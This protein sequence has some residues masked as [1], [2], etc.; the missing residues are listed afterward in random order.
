MGFCLAMSSYNMT[1]DVARET[2]TQNADT[3]QVERS[4]STY[5]RTVP[6]TVRGLGNLRGKQTGSAQEWANV[7]K[8]YN[9]IRIKTGTKVNSNDRII[10]V[11]DSDGNIVWTEDSGSTTVF[12]VV[13]VSPSIDPFGHLWEYEI[14]ANRATVQEKVG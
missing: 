12:D 3:G 4:W 1:M 14:F 2:I 9:F 13:G 6:C 11:R 10:N 7:F 5:L 8:E